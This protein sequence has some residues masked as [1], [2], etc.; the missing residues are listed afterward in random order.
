MATRRWT[1]SRNSLFELWLLRG[2]EAARRGRRAR[3]IP[4]SNRSQLANT[5]RNSNRPIARLFCQ[6]RTTD[7]HSSRPL[8]RHLRSLPSLLPRL[9]S[10]PPTPPSSSSRAPPSRSWLTS[11]SAYGTRT[12]P[13]PAEPR[14]P[15]P[16]RAPSRNAHGEQHPANVYA[17]RVAA[18]CL[19]RLLAS[20]PRSGCQLRRGIPPP[21][22]PLPVTRRS[23]WPRL[24]RPARLLHRRIPSRTL[25]GCSS[26]G[27][28]SN[29]IRSSSSR[30]SRCCSPIGRATSSRSP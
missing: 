22:A 13:S 2:R 8:Q 15:P 10:L 25:S 12:G 18:D 23:W 6:W 29:R 5:N 19:A 7:G 9:P 30:R 3:Q 20:Q 17:L 24:L 26:A 21:A 14:A 4:P 16:H 27:A 11:S 28:P 1:S